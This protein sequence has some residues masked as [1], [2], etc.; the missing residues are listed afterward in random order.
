MEKL[1]DL[2]KPWRWPLL[3]A[4]LLMLALF[5]LWREQLVSSAA[6][7]ALQVTFSHPAGSYE[8]AI[9]L[10]LETPNPQA[11]IY[12]T[13][14][15]ST[16]DPITSPVFEDPLALASAPP[17]VVAVRAQAVLPDGMAGPVT[18]ASYVMGLDAGLPILSI[19]ADPDDLWG[20][21]AGI[22]VNHDERGRE[23]ER[24]ADLTYI[25]VDGVTGFH[26]GSGLRIHGEWTRWFFDKKSLRLYFREEYGARKLEYPIFGEEG[27]VA[28]DHLYLHNSD[29]DL[30]LFRNQ[31]TER[32]FTQM[33][34][35]AV[36]GRP[37]LLFING[38]P[39]GIY[40]VRERID[41]RFLKQTYGVP[42]ASVNDTPN[43]PGRQSA[44]QREVD[45]P[46]WEHVMTFAREN[47][48]ADPDNYAYLQTQ[49]DLDNF[50]DYYL[51]EM[52]IANTDWPHHNVHQF[53]PW[54]QGGRWEWIVWDNDL[55][56]ERVDRQM[57]DHVL[58]VE[59]PLGEPMEMFLNKLLANPDF[60]NRFLTRAAD[61]LN[62]T[63]SAENVTAE[64][65]SSA[66]ELDAAIPLEQARWNVPENWEDVVSGMRTFAAERPSIMRQHFVES[67]NLPGTA[68]VSVEQEGGP[69]GWIAVNDLDPIVLPWQG[70][71]FIGTEINLRAVPPPGYA[72]EGWSGYDGP[73]AATSPAIRL[74]VAES[75]N[76]VAHFVPLDPEQ[77]Q[78]GDV[79]ISEYH[80][81]EA[82]P[83]EGDWFE[84]Q[85]R[86][87]GGVDLRGWRL[88]DNDSLAATDEGSLI[89]VD[90][91]LLADIPEGRRVRVIATRSPANDIL[92]AQD[93]WENGL[94]TIYSGN[95][96]IDMQSDP[97]FNLGPKDNLL[98]LAP[99]DI[100]I[101]L[102]SETTAVR[103]SDFG[104]PPAQQNGPG[105]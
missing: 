81:D 58:S 97:W 23:W 22:F 3:V 91:E 33:G 62:T 68:V 35:Y 12:Y 2:T 54:T 41:E 83:V 17:Q 56:F 87:A 1:P 14:D 8:E 15:G 99:G 78:G 92:F 24:P 67:F 73:E 72:F 94:L 45:L 20:E 42:A 34:G 75:N 50:I 85:V 86:R 77:Y 39:W 52:Y 102:W 36:R 88:T 21:E 38:E 43:I 31:L 60:Y 28:F 104:L 55:A 76:L 10:A 25:D 65:E 18:S 30:L 63:L 44:E 66:A 13:L 96:R 89:F 16:P 98:L 4:V 40:N 70:E 49:V 7:T 101:D 53:R 84:L 29:Q 64:V 61:L 26:T 80:V 90:D 5:M 82:G 59:H 79:I 95:G 71:Q 11:R 27:Q 93:G 37:V 46:H 103:R 51:L 74:H 57:V 48:L 105:D 6:D 47:D 100:P 69:P 9:T 32:L 19:V